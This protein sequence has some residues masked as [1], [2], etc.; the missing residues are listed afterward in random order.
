[1]NEKTI[2]D[3]DLKKFDNIKN[4]KNI[5]LYAGDLKKWN[6]TSVKDRFEKTEKT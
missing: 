5:Y 2:Y 6:M 3:E 1:M 4:K